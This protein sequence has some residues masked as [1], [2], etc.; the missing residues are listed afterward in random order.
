MKIIFLSIVRKYGKNGKN[1]EMITVLV[2][3][4]HLFELSLNKNDSA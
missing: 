2:K 1:G 3:G 4:A